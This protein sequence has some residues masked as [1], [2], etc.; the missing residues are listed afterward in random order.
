MNYFINYGQENPWLSTML[1]G[2]EGTRI[3]GITY[4]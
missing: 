4:I 1:L 2:V 3:I